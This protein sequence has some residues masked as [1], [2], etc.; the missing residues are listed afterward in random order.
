MIESLWAE[1]ADELWRCLYGDK[2]YISGPLELEFVEKRV[3]LITGVKKNIK[4]KVMKFW[5][6]LILRK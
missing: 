6:R 3:T 1:M 5:N 2:G 4:P